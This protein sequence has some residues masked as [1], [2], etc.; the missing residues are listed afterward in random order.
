MSAAPASDHDER[1]PDIEFDFFDEPGD[2][3]PTLVEGPRRPAGGRPP[4]PPV[5][6][7]VGITPLL[8]LAG[9]IAFAILIIVVVVLW[10]E[11]LPGRRQA[12]RL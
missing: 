7:Q 11:E 10:V 3:E 12:Q 8:R 9:L 1:Q 2:P 4:R 6:P 5:R